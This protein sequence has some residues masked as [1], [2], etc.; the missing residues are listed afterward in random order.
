M[1]DEL[2]LVTAS[3][4]N[5]FAVT[6][7]TYDTPN[8]TQKQ[9]YALA[10]CA[11]VSNEDCYLCLNKGFNGY[12]ACCLDQMG[13]WVASVN[14]AMAYDNRPFFN[15]SF[16]QMAASPPSSG[17][18]TRTDARSKRK[19]IILI[20]S[21]TAAA[22]L[23]LI[24]C[25]VII[26][27]QRT[28]KISGIDVEEKM[29]IP[30]SLLLPFTSL[31]VATNNFSNENK[32]GEGRF[33]PAFKGVL[34][35]GRPIVV[36]RLSN[37]SQKGFSEFR[38]E[39]A[40]VAQLQHKNLVKLL[41][42]C[43]QNKEKLL[44]YE[45]LSNACLDEH[46]FDP[47]RREKLDWKKRHSIIEGIARGLVYL[48]N[49]SRLKIIHRDLNA[50]NILLDDNMKPKISDFGLAKL[51]CST[52]SQLNT[53]LIA[54]TF[55]Y[56]APEY[57]TRGFFSTKSDVFS[58]GMVVL[59]IITGRRNSSFVEFGNSLN[60]QTFV[61]QN[62]NEGKAEEVVDQGLGGRYQMDEVS[63]CLNIGLLCIQSDPVERPCMSTV[64]LFL[65]SD[66]T[67][68]PVPSLPAFFTGE[69]PPSEPSRPLSSPG[70]RICSPSLRSLSGIRS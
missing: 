28:R 54:G 37:A 42:Y 3:S 8:H 29:G 14:C 60:L 7:V 65:R 16:L 5:L 58:Y 51:V 21:L 40:L 66:T 50:K 62:W 44:V 61:W 70:T 2:M 49:H 11:M 20:S 64:M 52:E 9:I 12:M 22:I 68:L 31:K 69:Y 24:F 30:D 63:K 35:D 46:L 43:L 15:I 53:K 56:M 55:G 32:L 10:W 67:E 57:A 26:I 4:L 36:N 47:A 34:P 45:Y 38:K 1:L 17:N 23:V 13:G 33:G 18:G 27:Y 19:N 41:G 48:H 6:T 59:E 25:G 39:V